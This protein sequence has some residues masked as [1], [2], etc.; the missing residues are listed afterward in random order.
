MLCR[1]NRQLLVFAL[2]TSGAGPPVSAA[3]ADQIAIGLSCQCVP[4]SRAQKDLSE[5]YWMNVHDPEF[6]FVGVI[7]H[8]NLDQADP[9]GRRHLVYFSRYLS[10]SD[11]VFS[12]PDDH[13]IRLTMPHIQRMFPE[14]EPRCVQAAHVW[15]AR[16]GL[17]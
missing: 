3:Y 9:S 8:T 11:P 15:Q 13:V 16:Y 14:L 1:I 12:A 6:P 5:L 17:W 2:A 4:R 10:A 7:E